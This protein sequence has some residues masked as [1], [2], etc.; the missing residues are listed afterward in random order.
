MVADQ[1]PRLRDRAWATA[2]APRSGSTEP[3]GISTSEYS[4]A[5]SAISSLDSAGCPVAVDASTVNT[6]AA[7]FSDRY[8][9]AIAARDGVRSW[10][11]LKY[12]AEASISSS[13]REKW[14][15]PSDSMCTWTSMALSDEVCMVGIHG[16][17]HVG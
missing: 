10:P 6:T 8:R 4:A 9:S 12:A 1:R 13:S 15:W 16:M 2:A 11:A 3:N 17:V 5:E 14:P 7:M